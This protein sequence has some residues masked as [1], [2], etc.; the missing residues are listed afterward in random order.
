MTVGKFTWTHTVPE[1]GLDAW[2]APD[3]TLPVVA[4]LIPGLDVQVIE[5]S[6]DW[7]Q[8][9]CSNDWEGWTDGRRLLPVEAGPGDIVAAELL[10]SLQTTV[11][12]FRALMDAF[13]AERIDEATLHREALNISLVVND[14]E[15]WI[16][17]IVNRRWHHFDGFE[18]RTMDL[19]VKD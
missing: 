13:A 17:D 19:P 2:A 11:D 12:A 18:L 15:A 7:A 5:R 3:S 9:R 16:L 10:E 4:R 1:E 8:I 14:S 6:G